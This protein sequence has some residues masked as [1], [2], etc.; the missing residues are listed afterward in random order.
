MPFGV[1]GF[2]N[3][4]IVSSC[5]LEVSTGIITIRTRLLYL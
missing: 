5:D 1:T 3:H 4:N 2:A